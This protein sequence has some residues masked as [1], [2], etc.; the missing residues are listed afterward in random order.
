MA[1]RL[2]LK[3]TLLFV[4]LLGASLTLN[5]TFF[6]P[7]VDVQLVSAVVTLERHVASPETQLINGLKLE[8]TL[9]ASTCVEV[10]GVAT[11]VA[12]TSLQ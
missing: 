1:A 12:P 6:M 4:G 7:S 10:A 9:P 3:L 2:K 8:G 11:V 5:V